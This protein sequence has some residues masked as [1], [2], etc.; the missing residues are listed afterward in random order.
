MFVRSPN[1]GPVVRVDSHRKPRGAPQNTR[2][3]PRPVSHIFQSDDVDTGAQASHQP[4]PTLI[5]EW[6]LLPSSAC[7][8]IRSSTRAMQLA[9]QSSDEPRPSEPVNSTLP[10]S[11]EVSFAESGFPPP[12]YDDL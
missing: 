8:P 3:T 10:V 7:I 2:R 6:V 12:A 1:V 11:T 5:E 9:R 4:S